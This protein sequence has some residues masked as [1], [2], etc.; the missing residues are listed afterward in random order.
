MT[1]TLELVLD[2]GQANTPAA[3]A[4]AERTVV[5]KRGPALKLHTETPPAVVRKN[6]D[7]EN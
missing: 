1:G 3:S 5:Y 7:G 4:V 6:V 2:D